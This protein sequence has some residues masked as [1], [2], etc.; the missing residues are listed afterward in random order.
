MCV[1]VCVFYFYVRHSKSYVAV[2]H[3]DFNL[4]INDAKHLSMYLLAIYI[5]SIVKCVFK[6]LPILKIGLFFVIKF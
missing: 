2:S 3:Y 4:V 5:S 6:Y 1:C